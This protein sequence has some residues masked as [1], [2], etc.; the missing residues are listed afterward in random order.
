[1]PTWQIRVGDARAELAKI[2]A[3]SV[4]C[5]VTSP[6]F[7][8]LR[9]YGVDGQIG[10]ESTVK[11]YVD[12]L[13]E[14]MR[15]VKRALRDDGVL[16]LNLGSSYASASSDPIPSRR[17]PR[18]RA[19]GSD[20]RARQD[21]RSIDRAYRGLCDGCRDALERRTTDTNRSS[22]ANASLPELTD[23]D[24]GR[25]D[26]VAASLA[27]SLPS[28]PASTM[29]ESSPPPQG[30]CSHCD[31]CGAC[32]SVL[33]SDSRDARLC[34]RR[35]ACTDGIDSRLAPSN[36]RTSGTES[37]G[38]ALAEPPNVQTQ[39]TA[40]KPKDLIP[41][42]WLVALA[43]QADGWYLRSALPWVKRGA[44]PES[45]KDRPTS[46]IEYVFMLT[47]QPR[48]YWDATAVARGAVA[49]REFPTWEQRKADGAPMR[50]GDPWQSGDVTK[51]A[52]V[53][54]NGST[55][56]FRNADL[57]F[58]SLSLTAD[59]YPT[60]EPQTV[61]SSAGPDFDS[62]GLLLDEDGDPLALDVNPHPWKEAHFA[63][64]PPKLVEPLVKAATSE[65]GA[66]AEC[67]APWVRVVERDAY[68]PQ[69][70][71][72]G[73]RIVDAS[74]RDKTR[75]LNGKS[76]EW[77]ESAALAKAIGW[78]KA[79]DCDGDTVAPCRV[80]DPFSGSGT[81][82]MVSLKLGRDAVGIELNPTFSEMTRRRIADEVGAM[83]AH[84]TVPT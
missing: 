57:F 44:M 49:H 33:G 41:I 83:F 51:W 6:P 50:R 48:Y 1:M 27:A 67:G 3:G 31:N 61:P 28:A 11:E 60:A 42:P 82:L 14:V 45:C 73:V 22:P 69:E 13:V 47:K 84:E 32:L 9:D 66:C 7:F 53:G 72:A 55:R 19:Y 71:A 20:G 5:A 56:N 29:I 26:S 58:D 76:V 75:K 16:W 23:R 24:T 59:D 2:E 40:F 25:R 63:T 12:A 34:V 64:F 39:Y 21:S 35:A 10:R 36:G 74:R 52:G 30:G 78:K 68:R 17:V 70:V 62:L 46:A 8:N 37:S 79:C 54:G 81:T 80:L 38:L 15:G 77:R 43:L 18:D 4:Q 65:R